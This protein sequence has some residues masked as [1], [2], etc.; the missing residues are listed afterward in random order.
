MNFG[1]QPFSGSYELI[2][3]CTADDSNTDEK[4]HQTRIERFEMNYGLY[5]SR[6]KCELVYH[7]FLMFDWRVEL[8]DKN[9]YSNE[10]TNCTF[11]GRGEPY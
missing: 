4:S 1:I 6:E 2:E 8:R 10:F 7:L 5:D 11:L 9:E 3:V